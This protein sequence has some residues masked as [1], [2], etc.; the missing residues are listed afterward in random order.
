MKTGQKLWHLLWVSSTKEFHTTPKNNTKVCICLS[1]PAMVY[2]SLSKAVDSFHTISLFSMTTNKFHIKQNNSWCFVSL[3][4]FL[5]T[6]L[7][8]RSD[9]NLR[10]SATLINSLEPWSYMCLLGAVVVQMSTW[11]HST[12]NVCENRGGTCSATLANSPGSETV[13]FL[14]LRC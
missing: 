12:T 6:R 1:C 3:S 10:Y 13:F 11:C 4:L 5:I 9:W 2:F 14:K 8:K 7:Q